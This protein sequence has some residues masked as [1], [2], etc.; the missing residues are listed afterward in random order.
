MDALFAYTPFLYGWANL[1]ASIGS[2]G[3]LPM[4]N[5][6]LLR[7]GLQYFAEDGGTVGA[8]ENT[9]TNTAETNAQTENQQEKQDFDESKLDKIIQSRVDRLLADERKK[10][11]E[12]QKKLT[13]MEREKLSDDEVKQL[14]IKER[15]DAIA[16]KEKELADRENKL[17]AIKAIKEIGLDDGSDKSLDLV[18]FV[19]GENEAAIDA[20]V[21]TFNDLVKRFVSAEVDKIYRTYGKTPTKSSAGVEKSTESNVVTKLAQARAD[22]AKKSNDI[23]N[24]YL[25]R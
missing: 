5:K 20:K 19:M 22:Q 14:E 17:Y 24:H 2:K 18:D 6:N 11:A 8:A 15:E 4:E 12:L 25:G 9:A 1:I 16:A 13:K 3:G 23:L 21:K 7:L 10:S